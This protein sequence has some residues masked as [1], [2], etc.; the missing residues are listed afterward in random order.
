VC[1]GGLMSSLSG[2]GFQ[3]PFTRKWEVGRG[4]GS[5]S[6]C[7]KLLSRLMERLVPQL[8]GAHQGEPTEPPSLP[9]VCPSGLGSLGEE[10]GGLPNVWSSGSPGPSEGRGGR[11]ASSSAL[12]CQATLEAAGLAT[13]VLLPFSSL[14]HTP[15]LCHYNPTGPEQGEGCCEVTPAG[16]EGGSFH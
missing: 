6:W 16:G 12:G 9:G 3:G 1:G 4:Q 8:S 10:G 13:S 2:L 14:S 7:Q 5:G 15:T 11:K